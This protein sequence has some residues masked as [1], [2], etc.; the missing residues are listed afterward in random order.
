MKRM[1]P[2]LG[3]VPVLVVEGTSGL[4]VGLPTVAMFVV[5]VLIQRRRA[6]VF[7]NSA[8]HLV[9][10]SPMRSRPRRITRSWE[11]GTLLQSDGEY[12]PNLAIEDRSIWISRAERSSLRA[13]SIV[14]DSPA[15]DVRFS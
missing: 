14:A 4:P 2:F 12:F 15:H 6:L 7:T 5:G 1:S 10:L 8:I 9:R 3:E 13:S 11:R